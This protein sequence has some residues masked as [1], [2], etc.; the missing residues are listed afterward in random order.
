VAA[1]PPPTSASGVMS[2]K[3]PAPT[4]LL[5]ENFAQAPSPSGAATSIS[6]CVS[7]ISGSIFADRISF[8][9][10]SSFVSVVDGL[11]TVSAFISERTTSYFEAT[12]MIYLQTSSVYVADI[13]H[14]FIRVRQKLM[15]DAMSC[16]TFDVHGGCADYL[17]VHV[18]QQQPVQL[19]QQL[20]VS[21]TATVAK[22]K[23][24]P[25][26]ESSKQVTVNT[27][28]IVGC[29]GRAQAVLSRDGV[30]ML[31]SDSSWRQDN[32]PSLSPAALKTES[33]T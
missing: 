29:V 9:A 18:F 28:Y 33:S 24:H 30:S 12:L 23:R 32:R 21:R 13:E 3:L 17:C 22:N 20:L 19:Q 2:T 10:G 5:R 11:S 15:H 27:H 4:L 6:A 1:G 31:I 8:A 26:L 25:C 7:E 16:G 14:I